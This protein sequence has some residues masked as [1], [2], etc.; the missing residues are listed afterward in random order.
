MS[1]LC[2]IM[3]RSI[4]NSAADLQLPLVERAT[5]HVTEVGDLQLLLTE[6]VMALATQG[7]DLQL[8]PVHALGHGNQ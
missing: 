6:W 8:L 7:A 2:M 5:T 3:H 4:A 1:I